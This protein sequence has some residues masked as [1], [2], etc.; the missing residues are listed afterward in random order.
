MASDVEGKL[1]TLGI[2]EVQVVRR[3]TGT[4]GTAP[5]SRARSALAAGLVFVVGLL[6][7]A[8]P[9]WVLIAVP[10]VLAVPVA[11]WWGLVLALVAAAGVGVHLGVD[12]TVP[13][14]QI[15]A[16]LTGFALA[17]AL[18]GARFM[19]VVRTL[20]RVSGESLRD[21]LTG[22]YNFAYFTD[23][24]AREHS[25]TARYGGALSLI[26]LDLDH[27]KSFNDTYGHAA[28]NELIA[29]V[30]RVLAREGRSTDIVARFGGEEFAL[31]ILGAPETATEVAERVRGAIQRLDVEVGYGH[32][33]GR[34][35]SAGVASLR[36]GDDPQDL[37]ERAD[38]ALYLSKARGRNRVSVAGEGASG[39]RDHRWAS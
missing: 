20:D 4:T 33:D 31:L 5:G 30:G 22:L 39:V 12:G 38:R 34:T 6:A 9:L 21:R 8:T 32:R 37:V 29:A 3:H 35:I 18:V 16:G 11:G 28:G 15:V 19:K 14:V 25:R 24:L 13:P 36:P 17:G 1:L 23:A 10:I 27:F 26:L 7:V 2:G